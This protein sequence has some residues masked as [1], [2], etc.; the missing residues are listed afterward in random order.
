MNIHPQTEFRNHTLIVTVSSDDGRPVLDGRAYENLA[1]IFHE[2]AIE[3]DVRVVVLRGLA[4]C[5]CLGG[6]FSEFLDATKHQ[7][8]IAAVTDMFR[9]LATFPKPV[10]A[11]VDGDAVGV[12]CTIL[13]HCDMVIASDESTFRV[14]FVD[15]GLVPDAA[16]SILAPQKL[17]YAGA[18]RFFCLGDTLR[19][20]DARMLGLVTEIVVGDVEEAAL[21]RARQLAKKPVAALLQTRDLLKGDTGALCDRIDQEISLFQQALQDDTTLRRLQRIA[22]LAA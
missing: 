5:F 3:D 8:L 14:P 6:D 16:T 18:F 4:G 13:F 7:R 21:G 20:A 9:T 19:A 1:R 22:R 11:C 10:L 15:F 17:G 12:G 2:A